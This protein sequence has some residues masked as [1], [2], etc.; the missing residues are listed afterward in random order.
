MRSTVKTQ[1]RQDRDEALGCLANTSSDVGGR[2][3][4]W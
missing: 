3:G 4:W 1:P 2:V